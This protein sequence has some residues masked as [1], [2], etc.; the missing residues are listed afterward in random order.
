MSRRL[1]VE[2]GAVETR[3]A[4][5]ENGAAAEFHVRPAGER[6]LLGEIRLGR[7]TDSAPEM[8]AFF[9]DI[10]HAT[11]AFL[12]KKD[13]GEAREGALVVAEVIREP[14]SGKSAR[15]SARSPAALAAAPL[16]AGRTAP[17]L[18]RP[19]PPFAAL[20]ARARGVSALLVA[21]GEAA[22]A[23]RAHLPGLAVEVAVGGAD[24]FAR[25][26]LADDFAESLRPA[27]PLGPTG[28]LTLDETEALTAIDIDGGGL[29][30][31][32]ANETAAPLAAREIRRRNLSGQIVIDFIG[33]APAI[34]AG[35][36]A[37]ARAL[38]PDPLKPDLAKGDLGGLV[39]VTRR[40]EGESLQRS[41]TVPC[42]V[43]TGRWTSAAH[44]AADVLR[45]AESLA[46]HQPGRP[47]LARAP[48]DAL[49]LLESRADVWRGLPL[50]LEVAA[51]P[52]REVAVMVRP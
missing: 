25:E 33:D 38:A 19:A 23:L 39:L 1:L 21:G 50:T 32:A 18:L 30:P 45:R 5:T 29:S 27:L 11:P 20:L 37:L 43:S 15:I 22:A 14:L 13:A 40:R 48:A 17:A 12:K 3:L 7:I 34:A 4:L 36:A 52:S 42:P 24:L 44:L 41:L 51:F 28:R 49:A 8:G 6:G 2:A 9:V 35:R 47:L 46:R 31:R 16:A 26:G 10:G